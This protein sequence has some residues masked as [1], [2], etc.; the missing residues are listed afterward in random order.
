MNKFDNFDIREPNNTE[1]EKATKFDL[2]DLDLDKN[3]DLDLDKNIKGA[4][5]KSSS[6]MRETDLKGKEAFYF[7]RNKWS[8]FIIGWISGLIIFNGSLTIMIG[9]GWLDFKH[10]KWF[11]ITV[12]AETFLQIVGL[13]Y[14]AAHFLFS[15]IDK[16]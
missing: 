8:W 16:N 7:H 10:Y 1:S 4:E 11:I 9:I 13:G 14:V 2:K 12:T 6:L 5:D 15:N 3:I